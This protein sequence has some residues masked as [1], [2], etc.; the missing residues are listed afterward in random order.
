MLPEFQHSSYFEI[1]LLRPLFKIPGNCET[2]LL[3]FA[4]V[5]GIP[6]SDCKHEGVISVIS[7]SAVVLV[8]ASPEADNVMLGIM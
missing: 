8:V 7:Q 2:V 1:R 4:G 6:Y 3:S 5:V